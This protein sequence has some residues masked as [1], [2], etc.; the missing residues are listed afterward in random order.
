MGA[1]PT[2]GTSLRKVRLVV[3]TRGLPRAGRRAREGTVRPPLPYLRDF[4]EGSRSVTA[5]T[6]L[7]EVPSWGDPPKRA[8]TSLVPTG[9]HMPRPHALPRRAPPADP[10]SGP[11]RN[12][13]PPFDPVPPTRVLTTLNV[14][15]DE[16]AVF[17][18]LQSW[19]SYREGR[20]LQQWEVFGIILQT[21]IEHGA[22]QA[23][24]LPPPRDDV[25]A[26]STSR[27]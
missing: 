2:Q 19:W 25:P 27:R 15:R 8:I 14:R 23:G 7:S 10:P 22:Q 5:A 4:A 9:A 24:F 6:S 11:P 13:F 1:N 3:R 21:A 20:S 16:K 18:A 17:D 26:A 12:P